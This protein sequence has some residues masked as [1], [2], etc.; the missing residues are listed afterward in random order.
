MKLVAATIQ[1]F[2]AFAERIHLEF[3][4]T[5]IFTGPNGFGKSSFFDAIE[6]CI[7]GTISRLSGTRDFTRA[8]DVIKNKFFG[9]PC[10]VAV[11]F[12]DQSNNRLRR[13]RTSRSCVSEFNGN[14]IDENEF[15]AL[16]GFS[17]PDGQDSLL[18]NFVLQQERITQFVRDLN[19]RRRYDSVL[20]L[21]E[22]STPQVLLERVQELVV[23]AQARVSE[24]SDRVA[25]AEK[26]VGLLEATV[27]KLKQLSGTITSDLIQT[28][29]AEIMR[30]IRS[31]GVVPSTHDPSAS[32]DDAISDRLRVLNRQ[33]E[34]SLQEWRAILHECD[35]LRAAAMDEG[36]LEQDEEELR[37]QFEAE[38]T[39]AQRTLELAE[40][41]KSKIQELEGK[42]KEILASEAEARSFVSNFQT[43][44]AEVR[45]VVT[46][47]EC[48]ICKRPIERKALLDIIDKEIG[49]LGQTLSTVIAQRESLESSLRKVR[50]DRDRLTEELEKHERRIAELSNILKRRKE[51]ESAFQ[52]LREQE[53]AKQKGLTHTN[54]KLF[55]ETCRDAVQKIEALQ[56]RTIRLSS[57]VEQLQDTQFLP[58]K[59]EELSESQRL[60]L[61]A[62]GEQRTWEQVCTFLDRCSDG[63][64]DGR[65]SVVSTT[66]ESFRPLIRA[67][68]ARLNP[69]PLFSDIDFEVVRAYKEA[70]LYFKV[71]TRDGQTVAYPPTIF[72]ASQ[73]NALA[74]CIFLALNLKAPGPLSIMM[75]DDPIQ[76][77]DDIN[78]LGFC[79]VI[80]QIKTRRQLFISTHNKDLYQLLMN[81]LRPTSFN[82]PVKG[83]RFEAWTKSGPDIVEESADYKEYEITLDDIRRLATSPQS[84]LS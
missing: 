52:K 25:A 73:L 68:Y 34:S 43:I 23:S 37:S 67:L 38:Q 39:A 32:F 46:S 4:D 70:E 28:Q 48:P 57:L 55:V 50:S 11:D 6:W 78:V 2:R 71:F 3:A 59:L 9:G 77:M 8:G 76:V 49:Q 5:N 42:L 20:S 47:D 81:K 79:D 19:P 51:V 75:V 84:S 66:L 53:L 41:P 29:Y 15:L 35:R 60:V 24:A 40:A 58:K 16:L 83:F 82:D 10:L 72:S 56:E 64:A 63:I 22:L 14:T 12:A 18:R 26:Q 36:I 62:S 80:R 31:E 21:L 30:E 61:E 65:S 45:R 33:L 69:H 13:V 27:S 74:L 1:G 54:F 7:F 44:L 17:G